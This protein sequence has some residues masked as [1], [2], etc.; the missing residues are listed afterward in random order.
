MMYEPYILISA[1]KQQPR[2]GMADTGDLNSKQYITELGKELKNLQTDI[3]KIEAVAGKALTDAFENAKN[4]LKAFTDESLSSQIGLNKLIGIFDDVAAKG[5]TLTKQATFL[6]QR[7][8]E[9]SKSFKLNAKEAGEVGAAYDDMSQNLATGGEEVRKMALRIDKLMPGMSKMI[10]G[11]SKLNKF[12]STFRDELF[13]TNAILVDHLGL[14]AEQ[15][16]KYQMLAAATGQS[17]MQMVGATKAFADE[18]EKNTGLAGQ[19][20]NI[21]EGVANLSEDIQMA[22]RRI[23]GSLQLAVAKAKLLGIEFSK[24]DATA[25]KMLNIEESVND[26][27]NYQLISGKRLVNQNGESITQK[28]RMAKLS[29]DANA[30]TEAMNE[31][32]ESQGDVLDG[33]NHYAK[34]QLAQLTGMSVAELTRANNMKKLMV[35]G[36]GEDEVKRI[37]EL[38]PEKFAAAAAKMDKADAALFQDIRAGSTLKSTDEL[39]ND[40]VSGKRTLK[41]VQVSEKQADA[42]EAARIAAIGSEAKGGAGT[43]AGAITDI[44]GYGITKETVTLVGKQQATAGGMALASEGL[45]QLSELLPVFGEKLKGFVDDLKAGISTLTGKYD[46]SVNVKPIVKEDAVMVND[47]VIQ[48]HPADK[49]AT[50]PDGAALL[51]STSTGQLGRAVDSMT[52]GGK[53]AVVDPGPIAAAVASAIQSAMAGMKIEMDGYNLAKA[54][55]F[56]NRT[57]NG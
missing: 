54:M 15:A 48:F 53:S 43:A 57:L 42:I 5:V 4:A 46:S 11:T 8:K 25:E 30:A 33:N 52:G 3:N 10:T 47:G 9:L 2:H 38:D 36:M 18:F 31:L 56:S 23:P 39:L 50:V 35:K 45:S 34:Q 55:E 7:N 41:V 14:T 22:Y 37:L 51:A 17:S 1:L 29:G 12:S 19:F 21:L 44:A 32:L 40:L 28:M 13:Q 49:F 27:L 6:E 20:G 24:I 16:E 26:E